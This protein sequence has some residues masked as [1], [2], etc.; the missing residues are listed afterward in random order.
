M[1]L[2]RCDRCHRWTLRGL[3]V[4]AIFDKKG[5][6]CTICIDGKNHLSTNVCKKC[7]EALLRIVPEKGLELRRIE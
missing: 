1:R 7:H 3:I 4:V 5:E 2:E 6:L